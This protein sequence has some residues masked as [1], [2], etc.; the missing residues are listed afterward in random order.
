MTIAKQF[1][2]DFSKGN[3]KLFDQNGKE[4]YYEDSK[5]DWSKQEYDQNNNRVYFEDSYGYIEDDRPKPCENKVVEIDGI[6]Y[7]LSP[8]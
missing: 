5:G 1:N 6:K 2:H 3:F 8:L 7:K 4:I